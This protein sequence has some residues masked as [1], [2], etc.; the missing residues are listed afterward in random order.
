MKKDREELEGHIQERFREIKGTRKKVHQTNSILKDKGVPLG[1]FED[2]SKGDQ[3]LSAASESLL[4]VITEVIHEVTGYDDMSPERWFSE[5]E[6]EMA[7]QNI[8]EV[9]GFENR[10]MLP[11]VIEDVKKIREDS[12][13]TSV[14]MSFLVQMSNSQLI[15]YDYK[16]QRSAVYVMKR[17]GVVPTPY[18]NKNSVKSIASEMAND[19]YL[20]DMI[21]LN[22]YSNEVKPFTYN[23][24]TRLFTINDGAVV[25]ILDGF[26]R[27]EGGSRAMTMNEYLNQ[28][29]I[30][31]IRSYDTPKA[32]KYFGQINTINPVKIERRKELLSVKN[33]D[34]VVK[35]LQQHPKSEFKKGKIASAPKISEITGQLTT[36]DIMSYGIEHSFNLK[37]GLDVDEVSEYLINFYKYLFG[38]YVDEFILDPRKYSNTLINHPLMFLGYTVIAKHFQDTNKPLKEL[39]EYIGNINFKDEKLVEI[40]NDKSK[41]GI[42]SNPLR[43]MVIEYFEKYVQGS[44]TV[45]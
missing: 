16:T 38:Y 45:G 26:H 31:S 8:K 32:Q 25:S 29:M 33:S 24:N 7:H 9:Y 42:N 40:F 19:D 36:F 23:E 30:L 22:V 39:K 34:L 2:I 15:F 37:S 44:V 11:I 18:L 41:R 28:D 17:D 10:L 43:K 5:N 12:F 13:L 4:C 1:T 27:L 21:T 6:I 20:E 35:E 14:K 3:A